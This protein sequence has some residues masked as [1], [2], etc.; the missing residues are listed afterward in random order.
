MDGSLVICSKDMDA[1]YHNIDVDVAVEE[2][3][4]DIKESDVELEV[5]NTEV[6]TLFL[7]C[8][9]HHEPGGDRA[10]GTD[11]RSA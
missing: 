3:K 11:P 10:R 1:F 7:A 2:A 9:I 5:V 6:I 4:Q 8:S